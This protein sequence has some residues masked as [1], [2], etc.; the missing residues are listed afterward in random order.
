MNSKSATAQLLPFSTP[1]TSLVIVG[2]L[3]IQLVF[4]VG[5]ILSKVLVDEFPPLIWA[6]MRAGITTVFM[7]AITVAMRRPHPRCDRKF[8]VPLL[9]LS[10]LGGVFTQVFF[11]VG[12]KYTTST[13]SAILHTLTPLITLLTV[14]LMGREKPT[15]LRGSGFLISF[16][17]VL[18]VSGAEKI[19]VGHSTLFGD[20]LT[21]GSCTVYGIFVAVSRDFFQ[22]YDRFWITTW[23]FVFTT[24]GL[25]FFAVPQLATFHWP[26]MTPMLWGAF[27]YGIF[28]SSLLG[29]FLIVW[30]LAHAPASKV[31]LCDYL[32][33][34]LVTILATI[35]LMEK[36]TLRTMGGTGLIF[37]GVFLTLERLPVGF[38]LSRRL[39]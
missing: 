32:Q 29:Y 21:M 31:A 4:A 26:T 25:T 3:A 27:L 2:L 39:S 12:L 15:L 18:I 16:I 35:F 23:L 14:V 38:R 8:F 30:V 20:V 13:N 10:A 24:F 1:S 17:G 7:F 9:W 33:P 11:L 34:V 22:K 19:R 5:Y 6:W 37:L 28:G 36:T